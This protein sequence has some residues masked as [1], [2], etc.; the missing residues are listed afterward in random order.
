MI[1]RNFG[2]LV[3]SGYP[4]PR[5][6]DKP[7][8]QLQRASEPPPGF[9]PRLIW[10]DWTLVYRSPRT[11]ETHRLLDNDAHRWLTPG[12]RAQLAAETNLFFIKTHEPPKDDYFPGEAAIQMVRHPGAACASYL[13]M[14]MNYQPDKLV[15]LAD[16]VRGTGVPGGGWSDYHRAWRAAPLPRLTL[17]YEDQL[18]DQSPAIRSIARFLDLEVKGDIAPWPLQ[19]ARKGNPR[20]NPGAGLDGW[21]A[22]FSEGDLELLG[23]LHGET[24]A[25]FGYDLAAPGERKLKR[26]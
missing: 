10:G 4:E 26:A 18:A 21:R 14:L 25:G 6:Q 9:P 7:K 3:S 20:R 5:L 19:E 8:L 23:E 13:H 16:I 11:G 17:R 1:Y 22:D 24:A 15:A 2:F 12:L